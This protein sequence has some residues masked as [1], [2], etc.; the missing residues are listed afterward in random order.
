MGIKSKIFKLNDFNRE[1]KYFI[2]RDRINELLIHEILLLFDQ[3]N[4]VLDPGFALNQEF[5]DP[6]LFLPDAA[7]I[8]L[9][10]FYEGVKGPERLVQ[11]DKEGSS[12]IVDSNIIEQVKDRTGITIS[13]NEHLKAFA[14]NSF[15][16]EIVVSPALQMSPSDRSLPD[17][18]L[19]TWPLVPNYLQ[20]KDPWMRKVPL[21]IMEFFIKIFFNEPQENL[22]IQIK[23]A[24]T[25]E[26]SDNEAIDLFSWVVAN[27]LYTSRQISGTLKDGENTICSLSIKSSKLNSNHQN[28]PV[29]LLRLLISKLDSDGLIMPN[30]QNLNS[31][32][33]LREDRRIIDF[34]K[35]LWLWADSVQKG[36]IPA[37]QKVAIEVKK[38]NKAL[39]KIGSYRKMSDW[40]LYLS[41]PGVVID[42]A[43]AIPALGSLCGIAGIGLKMAERN[44]SK[45]INWLLLLNRQ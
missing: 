22:S 44:L 24:F 32:L 41:L 1:I 31:L 2:R 19:Q 29:Q 30:L 20:K 16:K 28:H 38:A 5:D 17:L 10:Q 39:K 11:K 45:E 36:D 42:A 6:T 3:V 15:L 37:S 43:I 40:L 34:R 4:F 27:L 12:F 8:R 9:N 7:C 33:H 18:I 25:T 23:R 35:M 26:I 21:G 13:S 14:S